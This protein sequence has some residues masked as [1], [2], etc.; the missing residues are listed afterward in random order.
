ME[1]MLIILILII[2][3][4]IGI[5]LGT[6]WLWHKAH[7]KQSSKL[8]NPKY[9]KLLIYIHKAKKAGKSKRQIKKELKEQGWPDKEIDENL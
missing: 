9:P 6:Y 5:I 2:I 8:K 1:I 4:V 3:F 7:I